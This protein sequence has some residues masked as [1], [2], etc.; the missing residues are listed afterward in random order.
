M[1]RAGLR[2]PFPEITGPDL[3]DHE[4]FM[5]EHIPGLWSFVQDVAVLVPDGAL[6]FQLGRREQLLFDQDH[7]LGH[8]VPHPGDVN[9]L[10]TRRLCPDHAAVA[11]DLAGL[12]RDRL[13][14]ALHADAV[15]HDEDVLGA[16]DHRQHCLGLLVKF[17]E[18]RRRLRRRPAADR[19]R[20][21]HHVGDIHVR[22]LGDLALIGQ[23]RLDARLQRIGHQLLNGLL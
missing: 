23:Q 18:E 13:V 2:Y 14:L 19:Y 6:Q 15:R 10:H 7:V 8:P 11:V 4:Q 16:A 17:G 22:K 9:V 12:H 20:R 3:V 5:G 1:Q 21:R